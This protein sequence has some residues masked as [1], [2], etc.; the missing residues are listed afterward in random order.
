[1]PL[2]EYECAQC[3]HRFEELVTGADTAVACP[4]CG[5]DEVRRRLS[6][7]AA[8]GGSGSTAGG[9]SCGSGFS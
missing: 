7:F 5:T 8:S 1:M 9:A 3:G 6:V 2:F 4:K